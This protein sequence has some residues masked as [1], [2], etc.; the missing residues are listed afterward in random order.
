MPDFNFT[1]FWNAFSNASYILTHS[2]IFTSKSDQWMSEIGVYLGELTNELTTTSPPLPRDDLKII[3]FQTK[4][5]KMVSKVR[6]FILKFRGSQK[7]NFATMCAQICNPN[8]E[9]IYLENPHFI[10][11]DA[12]SKATHTVKLK[13]KYNIVYDKR[14]AYGFNTFPCGYR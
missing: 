5:G 3:T 2:V 1:P 7:L 6:G 11:R 14:V 10:K 12:K 9:P 13:K 8:G 4:S